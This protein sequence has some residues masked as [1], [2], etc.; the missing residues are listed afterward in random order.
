MSDPG[1]LRPD[2][3]GA[4]QDQQAVG[5]PTRKSELPNERQP[6]IKHSQGQWSRRSDPRMQAQSRTQKP[7]DGNPNNKKHTTIQEN[8]TH[9]TARWRHLLRAQRG[10][11]LRSILCLN[12]VEEIDGEHIGADARYA[13]V[14]P[15]GQTAET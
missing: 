7:V 15:D 14:S 2:C 12:R 6:D 8:T 13:R 5:F 11:I 3:D 1:H 10:V 4:G 9:V